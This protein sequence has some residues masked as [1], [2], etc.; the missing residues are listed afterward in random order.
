MLVSLNLP[1]VA[2]ELA[3][4]RSILV[5]AC[6]S[7]VRPQQCECIGSPRACECS[8]C[9][10]FS[11]GVIATRASVAFFVLLCLQRTSQM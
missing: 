8:G 9:C 10:A 11:L 3:V 5:S 4:P 6:F 1:S 7:L 2:G